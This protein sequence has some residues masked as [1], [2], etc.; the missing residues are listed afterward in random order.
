[1]AS[2]VSLHAQEAKIRI[3]KEN[4]VLRLKP[5]EESVIIKK[6]PIG[7]E[8]RVVKTTNDWI[9]VGMPPDESGVVI[10]GYI[11]NSYVEFEIEPSK[12]IKKKKQPINEKSEYELITWKQNLARAKSRRSTGTV[13]AVSGGLVF[14]ACMVLTFAHQESTFEFPFFKQK[15]RTGYIIGDAIGLVALITGFAITLPA[16]REVKE[17]EEEGKIKGYLKVGS[18]PEYKAAGVQFVFKF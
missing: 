8:L 10:T 17:I 12:A 14:T 6:L 4:A 5:S 9:M 15:A 1:M 7:A 16:H 11:H 18:L 13:L 2:A 3:I